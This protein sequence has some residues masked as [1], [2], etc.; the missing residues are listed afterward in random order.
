MKKESNIGH[1]IT[2]KNNATEK[3]GFL[4]LY[5]SGDEPTESYKKVIKGI[6]TLHL[7]RTMRQKATIHADPVTDFSRIEEERPETAGCTIHKLPVLS[8]FDDQKKAFKEKLFL[9][10]VRNIVRQNGAFFP[11]NRLAAVVTG[12]DFF[13]REDIIKKIEKHIE[14]GQNLLI[15]GPRRYGKTSIMRKIKDRSNDYG[16]RP[17]MI[18]LESVFTPEEFISKICVEV[19]WRGKT[20]EEKNEKAV[21]MEEELKDRWIEQGA[22][23]FRKLSKNKAN[24]LFLL[25]ECPYMLDSFLGKDV[26]DTS[27]S[28]ISSRENTKRFIKWFR[29]QRDLSG[30]QCVYLLTG[31]INL[32]PYLKDNGLD[33]DSFSDCKEV[34]VTFFDSETVRTYIEGLLLGQKIFLPREVINELVKLTTP[35]IPYFIQI[36]MNHVVSLYRKNSQFSVED[37]KQT[38]REQI[39]GPEGRRLFDAFQR[40]FERY[41]RRKPGAGALLGEL[42]NAGDN[43]LE[44][45]SLKNSYSRSSGFADEHEFDIVLRYLEYDF[46]IEKIKGTDKYRFSSPILRDYWQKNQRR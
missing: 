30:G 29:E 23:I 25:D 16:L 32:K 28:D 37:L 17:I 46:Y 31:S 24:L 1:L 26:R 10:G 2:I 22:K 13:D 15:C 39:I 3:S 45:S 8:F 5:I 34:R 38:Y 4:F 12:S 41:G 18:D 40:H 42:S 27:E 36:V 35:G 7:P 20:E 11:N 14:K 19:E 9:S 44:K 21:K 33:K 6:R 43:G